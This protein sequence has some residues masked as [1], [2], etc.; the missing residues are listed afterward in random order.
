[1]ELHRRERTGEVLDR[2]VL[3]AGLRVVQDEVA[4]AERAALGVLAGEA[5]RDALGEQRGEGQRLGVRPQ[6]P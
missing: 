4:L 5:D 6:R 1:V 2:A 3:L